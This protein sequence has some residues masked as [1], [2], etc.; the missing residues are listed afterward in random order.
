MHQDLKKILISEQDIALKC[1]ELGK[2]ISNDYEDKKIILV[3]LLKGCVPFISD[4]SKHITIPMLIDYM[5]VSSY[6]GGTYSTGQI[7]VNKDLDS[8][9]EGFDVLIAEDIVD[10][11]LT[12]K[13]VIEMLYLKGANSVKVVTLLDKPVGRIVELQADYVGF[14]IPKEF[15]VGY[16]LDYMQY[17]RNLPYVGV[18]K[19]EIYSSEEV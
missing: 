12:L 8:N 1:K 7:K 14:T 17:Y 15:V 18:L 6:H 13:T 16:G 19:E 9:I 2:I 5:D 4:L 10:T 11:G 3:G